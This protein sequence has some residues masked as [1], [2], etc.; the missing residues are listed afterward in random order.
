MQFD[1]QMV[2]LANSLDTFLAM[3]HCSH[4]RNN[5][6]YLSETTNGKA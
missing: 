4:P 6:N 5:R 1:H 3:L 2:A